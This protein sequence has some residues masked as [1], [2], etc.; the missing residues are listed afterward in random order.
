MCRAQQNEE[1][2]FFGAAY[3]N[4]NLVFCSEDGHRKAPASST[5]SPIQ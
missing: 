5:R 4:E 3:H 2:L 1:K